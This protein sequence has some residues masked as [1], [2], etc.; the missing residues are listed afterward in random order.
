MHYEGR[1]NDRRY[2]TT[3]VT[4]SINNGRDCFTR[5]INFGMLFD[6]L[7]IIIEYRLLLSHEKKL[8][9]YIYKI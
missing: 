7:S 2:V 1:E 5:A 6:Y 9:I 4:A 3:R 8:C